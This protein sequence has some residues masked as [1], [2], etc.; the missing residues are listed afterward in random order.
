MRVHVKR[1]KLDNGEDWLK[2]TR[3]HKQAADA[4]VHKCML[5][6]TPQ[7]GSE[8]RGAPGVDMDARGLC[9]MTAILLASCCSMYGVEAAWMMTV[10]WPWCLI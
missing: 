7:E 6:L 10:E 2:W 5:A 1:V 4:T 8:E 3:L 9:G